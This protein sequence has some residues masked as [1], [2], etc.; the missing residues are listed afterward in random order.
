M[1]NRAAIDAIPSLS[2]EREVN[3][4]PALLIVLL[5]AAIG[6]VLMAARCG[7]PDLAATFINTGDADCVLV[8]MRSGRTVL[9]DGGGAE[10]LGGKSARLVPLLFA[11]G[12][13]RLDAV[14]ITGGG[15]DLVGV[16]PSLLQEVPVG[17]IYLP[18]EATESGYGRK[19]CLRAAQVRV[20]V[21]PLAGEQR[22]DLGAGAT[23]DLRLLHLGGAEPAVVIRIAYADRSVLLV[24][25]NGDANTTALL[26]SSPAPADV[27]RLLANGRRAA[28]P[29]PFLR[30]VGPQVAV[31]CR[32]EPASRQEEEDLGAIGADLKALGTRLFRTGRD[33]DITVHLGRRQVRVA[34][35]E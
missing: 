30:A 27:F 2:G 1:S 15:R 9:I 11:R 7:P 6:S 22:L 13:R 32:A 16:I 29:G 33:G 18:V 12:V 34:T 28:N 3:V 23:V 31:L 10:R 25:P 21:Y 14:V 24:S 19:V 8:R 17:A 5:I 20:P 4:G 26:G 35:S